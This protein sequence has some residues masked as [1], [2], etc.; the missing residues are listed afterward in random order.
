M[1]ALRIKR[2]LDWISDKGGHRRL[3]LA[4]P[5]EAFNLAPIRSFIETNRWRG[6][7]S[8]SSGK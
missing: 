5:W 6:R 4:E 8:S 1:F 3:Q 7:H 2:T